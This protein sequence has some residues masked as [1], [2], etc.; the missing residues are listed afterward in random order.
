MATKVKKGEIDVPKAAAAIEGKEVPAFLAKLDCERCQ[1]L[2]GELL[3]SL[4]RSVQNMQKIAA[5]GKGHE[6]EAKTS[7]EYNR[8]FGCA[9]ACD[10]MLKEYFGFPKA[11][12]IDIPGAGDA[13]PN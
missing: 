11:E 2:R 13:N 12:D 4:Q 3:G 9:I 8:Y 6:E 1:K 7:A 10:T 5:D